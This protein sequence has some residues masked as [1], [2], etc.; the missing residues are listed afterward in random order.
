MGG[1]RLSPQV[2]GPQAAQ[3]GPLRRQNFIPNVLGGQDLIGACQISQPGSAVNRIAETVALDFNNFTRLNP[4]LHLDGAPGACRHDGFCLE[5]GLKADACCDSVTGLGEDGKNTISQEFHD[6]P[7]VLLENFAELSRQ[8]GHQRRCV[9]VAHLFEQA[10][11]SNDI[12][13]DNSRHQ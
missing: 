4:H 2:H 6:P 13:K 9:G 10:R 7:V 11:A 8:L 1:L 5:A 12:G 3:S